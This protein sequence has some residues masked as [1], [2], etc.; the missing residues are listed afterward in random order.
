MTAV[1]IVAAVAVAAAR[2]PTLFLTWLLRQLR[3]RNNF[4]IR[5]TISAFA[6]D[7]GLED[8]LPRKSGATLACQIAW[9]ELLISGKNS[10]PISYMFYK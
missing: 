10:A 7:R 3:C 2:I 9:L 4:L 1:K 5:R 6:I 8:Y